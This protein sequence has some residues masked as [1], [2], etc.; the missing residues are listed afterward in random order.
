MNLLNLWP[1]LV[2]TFFAFCMG[3]AATYTKS[4]RDS[5]FYL[6]VFAILSLWGSYLWVTAS[7]KL[8]NTID[9]LMLSMVWDL[10]M[11]MA[12]YAGPILLKCENLNW[13]AYVSVVLI[14]IGIVWFKL[15]T[16]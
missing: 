13:Q 10:L 9:I 6:P 5:Q 16:S 15:A 2:C 4:F 8:D 11:I 1:I 14:L 12:Y 7:R 3:A